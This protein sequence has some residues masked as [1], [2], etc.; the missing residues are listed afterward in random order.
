[1][2]GLRKLNVGCFFLKFPGK[3]GSGELFSY[4]ENEKCIGYG[5]LVHI[6]WKD[7]NAEISFIMDTKLEKDFFDKHWAI[8]L[9]LI[10]HIAFHELKLHKIQT[11]AF[12]VRPN[13]YVILEK[14]NYLKEAVLKEHYFFNQKHFDVIIHSKYNS[15]ENI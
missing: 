12:D 3:S 9:D 1:M 6:N 11:F 10:E 4:L 15:C 8:F 2:R 5:G 13:L 7:K 14:N